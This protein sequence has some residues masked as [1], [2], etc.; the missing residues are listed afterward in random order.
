MHIITR[1]FISLYS[2]YIMNREAS[3][4][5]LALALPLLLISLKTGGMSDPIF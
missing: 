1:L 4:K 5:K 3:Y 2:S